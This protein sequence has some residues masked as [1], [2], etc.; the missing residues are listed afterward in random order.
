MSPEFHFEDFLP[1]P[2]YRSLE[3]IMTITG[4]LVDPQL[5][6]F[7]SIHNVLQAAIAA[8]LTESLRKVHSATLCATDRWRFQGSVAVQ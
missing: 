8:R 3:S 6:D 2:N 4:L 5:N 7:K 1:A